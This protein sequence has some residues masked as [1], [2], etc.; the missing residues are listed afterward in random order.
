MTMKNP[1]EK[2]DR[3]KALPFEKNATD[4]KIRTK[5]RNDMK[6]ITINTIPVEI[7][8][9]NIKNMYLKLLPPDGRV[10]ISAPV[11]MPQ[12]AIESFIHSKYGWILKHRE[13]FA[14]AEDQ[15]FMPPEYKTG[16]MVYL[17]GRPYRLFVLYNSM[18]NTVN[19]V[20]GS[21][22]ELILSV[23]QEEASSTAGQREDILNRWLR[24]ELSRKISLL[25]PHWERAVGKCAACWT[26]RNMKTRWGTCNV[27]SGK[28]CL[29]LQLVKKDPD[30]LVYVIV[31]EL[32]HLHEKSHNSVFKAYM[33]KY[34]PDWRLRKA[35][36]NEKADI[37]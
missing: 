18:H 5:I 6:Q 36:L 33:D 14:R 15:A 34:L 4:K 25:A 21:D 12:E 32:V 7:E 8:K 26:I 3:K 10:H 31:H 29:N 16:D 19:V 20:A 37:F 11:R 27:R 2:P 23:R 1:K 22:P 9:K 30:C 28:I 13:R 35:K 24:E 17:W